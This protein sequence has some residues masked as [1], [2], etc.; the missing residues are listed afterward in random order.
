MFIDDFYGFYKNFFYKFFKD[1]NKVFSWANFEIFY[2]NEVQF[3]IVLCL[4]F[5]SL[6]FFKTTK[7]FCIFSRWF[8]AL[9]LMYRS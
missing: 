1:Y 9:E 8:M 4:G 5:L 7:I 2:F 3:T 6:T